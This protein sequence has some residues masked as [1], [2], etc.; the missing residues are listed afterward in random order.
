MAESDLPDCGAVATMC[1][2]IEPAGHY[3]AT[4]H[5]CHCGSSWV[6]PTLPPCAG[7]SEP[8]RCGVH[9]GDTCPGWVGVVDAPVLR[10]P[11]PECWTTYAVYEDDQDTAFELMVN[12]YRFNM[13]HCDGKTFEAATEA[14]SERNRSSSGVHGRTE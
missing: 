14:V 9:R 5:L 4:A 12:H 8:E 2:C 3:P 7:C 1:T 11:D 10:C 6:V 13:R